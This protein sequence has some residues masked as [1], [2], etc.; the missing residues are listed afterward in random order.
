MPVREPADQGRLQQAVH[1]SQ[2][3]VVRHERL[4]IDD[5]LGRW[6]KGMP[7]LHERPLGVNRG[8]CQG[9]R[10]LNCCKTSVDV[11]EDALVPACA[12]PFAANVLFDR[13]VALENCQCH[14]PKCTGDFRS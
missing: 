2:K 14:P 13:R 6:L 5:C 3:M 11:I 10:T 1:V 4:Q 7:S 8:E 12:E 9:N